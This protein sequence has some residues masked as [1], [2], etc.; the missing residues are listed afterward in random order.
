MPKIITG[1]YPTN[2]TDWVCDTSAVFNVDAD[3]LANCAG[4]NLTAPSRAVRSGSALFQSDLG[5]HCLLK[6]I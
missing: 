5:L 3:R 6:P 4:P 2:E 1:F